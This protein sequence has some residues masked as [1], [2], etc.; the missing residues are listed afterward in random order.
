MLLVRVLL[1]NVG[2]ENLRIP[3]EREAR[4]NFITNVALRL[5][6]AGKKELSDAVHL[7][8]A[9]GAYDEVIRAQDHTNLDRLIKTRGT[10]WHHGNEYS[11]TCSRTKVGPPTRSSRSIP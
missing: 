4:A 8:A 10:C 5:D 11:C 1:V 9:L 7:G 6:F 3:H 2:L